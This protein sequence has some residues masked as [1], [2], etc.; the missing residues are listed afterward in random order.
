[1]GR[2]AISGG[3][4]VSLCQSRGAAGSQKQ[5]YG[6]HNKVLTSSAS[7][8]PRSPQSDVAGTVSVET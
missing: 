3:Q 8:G 6:N 1:M 5:Q 2:G 7:L 4:W